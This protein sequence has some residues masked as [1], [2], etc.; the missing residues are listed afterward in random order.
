M[1]SIAHTEAESTRVIVRSELASC[2]RRY[3]AVR[4]RLATDTVPGREAVVV[5]Q[6]GGPMAGKSGG[7][8]TARGHF[9][10][11]AQL[12]SRACFPEPSIARSVPHQRGKM[13]PC[14]QINDQDE[15]KWQ[16]CRSGSCSACRASLA[17]TTLPKQGLRS[18]ASPCLVAISHTCHLGGV[19]LM[20]GTGDAF[21][22]ARTDRRK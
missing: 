19:Q 12:S 18:A 22:R 20:D 11:W 3:K 2:I 17:S 6:A 16:S 14:R 13:A 15:H 1:V 10:I 5:R 7:L 8:Q 4:E 21:T 9:K